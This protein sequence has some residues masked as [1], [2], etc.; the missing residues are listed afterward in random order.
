MTTLEIERDVPLAP[1]TT[2][3]LGGPAR[4]LGREEWKALLDGLEADG[5]SL[6]QSE[7]RMTGFEKEREE[8]AA[9]TVMVT[10]HAI[11]AGAAARYILQGELDVVWRKR[12][13]KPCATAR[14]RFLRDRGI[15]RW[16]V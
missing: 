7:W 16:R 10:L 15:R 11:D 13:W 12:A 9:S 3:E 4:S 5:L 1:L 6:V 8:G 14:L 2:L